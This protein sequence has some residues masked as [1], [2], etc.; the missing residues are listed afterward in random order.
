MPDTLHA[1]IFGAVGVGKTG[2]VSTFP[3]PR[4]LD[5]DG[6]AERLL[7]RLKP[8]YDWAANCALFKEH[9][10]KFGIIQDD[11]HFAFD[12]ACTTVDKWAAPAERAK[13]ETLVIDTGTTLA[14]LANNK[15]IVLNGKMK[16]SDTFRQAGQ[17]GVMVPKIQDYGSERSL[18]EQFI[19]MCVREFRD[20]NFLFLCHE[21]EVTNDAGLLTTIQPLLTGK[22][23][24][25]VPGMFGE[26]WN[27][28]VE[29]AGANV[30]RYLQTERDGVRVCR[31][32]SGVTNRCPASYSS[33]LSG[34]K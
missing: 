7:R 24:V 34:G 23:A 12:D 33:I 22:G 6:R 19:S 14:E 1:L 17:F 18:M 5:F 26:V 28:R 16:L 8:D 11:T 27:L 31:S 3:A 9:V 21:K 13:F 32:D 2:I 29:G 10:N 25:S 30:K 15:A 20:K 4:I